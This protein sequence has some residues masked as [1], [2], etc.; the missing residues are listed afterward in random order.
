MLFYW[1]VRIIG[2]P[3][4]KNTEQDGK[5]QKPTHYVGGP[6]IEGSASLTCP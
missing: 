6:F 3:W 4:D 2:E 5:Q 1:E